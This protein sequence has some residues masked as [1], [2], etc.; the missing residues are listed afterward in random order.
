MKASELRIGNVLDNGIVSSITKTCIWTETENIILFDEI[1]PIPLNEEWLTRLG[2]VDNE[3]YA[4]HNIFI[5]YGNHIGIKGM[6]GI[7]KPFECKYVHQ[8]QNLYFSLTGE[9]LILKQ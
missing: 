2:F 8:L 6:L 7:V 3:K 9:E 1:E 5:W 4:L